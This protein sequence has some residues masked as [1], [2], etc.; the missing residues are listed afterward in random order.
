[1]RENHSDINCIKMYFI[2][3]FLSG[4]RM[5]LSENIAHFPVVETSFSFLSNFLT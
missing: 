2:I 3:A 1:M 4:K 5:G